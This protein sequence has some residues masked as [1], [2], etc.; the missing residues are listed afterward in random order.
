MNGSCHFVF[1]LTVGSMVAANLDKLN[2]VLPNLS[3]TPS[4]ITLI[5]MG[6]IVGGIMP[7]MDNPK[8]SI[9]K[10][11]EPFSNIVCFIGKRFGRGGKYHRGI[12][13]DPFFYII[14]IILSYLHF[15]PLVGV[16]IGGMTH[17]YLDLYNSVG[18]PLF[19][20]LKYVSLADI[21]AGGKNA[22]VFTYI[23]VI[24]TLIVGIGIN[25][26]LFLPIAAY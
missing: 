7:D 24:T 10:I 21:N 23:N 11:T 1:S 22:V 18:L 25:Y 15:T 19:F 13:H 12:L 4:T 20:G 5:I 9:A 2:A 14:G 16:F 17:I 3:F 26:G 6:S 8:S